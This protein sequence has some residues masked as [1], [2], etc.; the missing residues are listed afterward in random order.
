M[1]W[2]Q[3][4]AQEHVDIITFYNSIFIPAVKPLL[5]ELGP[6]GTT[7]KTNRVPEVSNYNDGM[8]LFQVYM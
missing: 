6:A 5:V 1:F 2:K 8:L 7:A 4:T 3:R